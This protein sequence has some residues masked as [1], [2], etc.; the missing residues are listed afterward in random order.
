MER[1]KT[2]ANF[3]LMSEEKKK[4]MYNKAMILIKQEDAIKKNQEALR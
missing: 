3:T 1:Q 4:E 2:L